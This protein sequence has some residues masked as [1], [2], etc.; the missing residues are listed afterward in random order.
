[1][2]TNVYLTP[3]KEKRKQEFPHPIAKKLAKRQKLASLA[4]GLGTSQV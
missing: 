4:M 2:L 3:P 1:M